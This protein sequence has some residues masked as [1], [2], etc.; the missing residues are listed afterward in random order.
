MGGA[1]PSGW[2]GGPGFVLWAGFGRSPEAARARTN[3]V[4]LPCPTD[5]CACARGLAAASR[6]PVRRIRGSGGVRTVRHLFHDHLGWVPAGMPARSGCPAPLPPDASANSTDDCSH[7]CVRMGKSSAPS[8]GKVRNWTR[9]I[10]VLRLGVH[11]GVRKSFQNETWSGLRL[12]FFTGV[13]YV[14]CHERRSNRP[15]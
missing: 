1:T 10:M 3:F 11:T 2:F 4:P 5:V 7:R 9:E 13:N 8:Y 6:F 15:D 14:S 12:I